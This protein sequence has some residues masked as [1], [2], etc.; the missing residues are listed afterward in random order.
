VAGALGGIGALLLL[1]LLAR[2]ADEVLPWALGCLGAGYALSLVGGGSGV[3]EGVPLV[4]V[5]LLLCA[6]LAVWSLDE[7]PGISAERPVVAGRVVG[8]VLLALAS[9]AAATL[10]AALTAAPVGGGLAWTV[11]GAAAAVL[12]VGVAARL[13]RG[14]AR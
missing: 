3:D 7:R 12:T 1:L 4:A 11:L 5:A 10:I 13:A 2:G 8:L 9:L 14:A 6:E